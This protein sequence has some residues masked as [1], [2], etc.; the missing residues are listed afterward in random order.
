MR[1]AYR[2]MTLAYPWLGLPMELLRL[3]RDSAVPFLVGHVTQ[4]LVYYV[5]YEGVQILIAM[6][7]YDHNMPDLQDVWLFSV[8]MMAEYYSI[9]YVRSVAS[10]RFFPRFF[11][12]FFVLYH[13]YL[14]SFPAG[15]HSA[16]MMSFSAATFSLL[17]FSLRKMEYPAYMRGDVTI[18]RP[19]G[20]FN[21]LP[22]S[23]SLNGIFLP[24]EF[25][26]FMP[27]N[28]RSRGVYE[29]DALTEDEGFDD[30]S[31]GLLDLE[32]AELGLTRENISP[33]RTPLLYH[34]HLQGRRGGPAGLDGE[35]SMSYHSLTAPAAP[36]GRRR[37]RR[38]R[39]RHQQSGSP[40]GSGS[41]QD[42]SDVPGISDEEHE[43]RSR[44]ATMTSSYNDSI[45]EDETKHD[46]YGAARSTAEATRRAG[47]EENGILARGMGLFAVS[48]RTH[49]SY[50]ALADTDVQSLPQFTDRRN[51]EAHSDTERDVEMG[52]RSFR[53]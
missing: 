52:H 24:P 44:R 13:I 48:S 12:G 27:V 53:G 32:S 30:G 50:Q 28:G 4:I 34:H 23:T 41:S 22:Y 45:E 7:I 36:T 15:F 9:V 49:E 20:L 43:N 29:N 33:T 40:A 21:M 11:A 1:T 6:W 37:R 51:H 3:R 39:H 5:M 26:M 17:L 47:G 31:D 46:D 14:F 2:L 42:G 10:I 16:A 18:D 8:M 38:R 25:T 35:S 19:R